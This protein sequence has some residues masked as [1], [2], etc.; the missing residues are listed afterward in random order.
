MKGVIASSRGEEV[1]SQANAEPLVVQGVESNSDGMI[2]AEVRVGDRART[3]DIL[4]H[5]QVL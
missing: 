1:S 3:G 2:P 5:S 4:I